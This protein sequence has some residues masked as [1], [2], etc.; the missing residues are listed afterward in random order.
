[1]QYS[2]VNLSKTKDRYD[3]RIDSEFYRTKFLDLEKI[4]NNKPLILLEEAALKVSDGTHF[5][6]T[7]YE[8]GIPFLSAINIQENELDLSRNYQYISPEVHR[9]LYKRCDP[10]ANDILLR[11]VGVGPRWACV[12]PEN[13][14]E[15]SIFVSVAQIRCK[16]SKINRYF[17]ST[18]IN[19]CYGQ[20]QLLRFNK[21]ISQP[22]LHLEDI[23]RLLIPNLNENF[24]KEIERLYLLRQSN[25]NN[26]KKLF[27]EAEQILLSELGLTNWKPGHQ[28]SFVKNY[29]DSKNADRID[30]E[31]FQPIYDEI[32]NAIKSYRDGWDILGNHFIQ[33]KRGFKI[34]PDDIYSYVEISCVRTSD[35]DIEPLVLY[36]NELPP[37]AKI[38]LLRDDILVSKVRPYRGA[39]G[40]IDSD[41]YVGSSA[42]TVLQPSG[43]ITKEALIALL[44]TKPYLLLSLKF[45]T[46]TSYPTIT[47]NDVLNFPIPLLSSDIQREIEKVISE[48]YKA[49]SASK[50]ILDIAKHGVEIA[51]EKGEGEAQDWVS[52]EVKNNA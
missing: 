17:L 7:Y 35:G 19:C 49:K 18:F 26:S 1:M 16:P 30:A 23:R 44:R 31:Y 8:E 46:G 48:A 22:D 50:K 2:T 34:I 40:I 37:N 13:I 25:I 14:N 47:D 52:Q 38:K 10:K 27:N 29:S 43:S 33:N 41:N 4:L 9:G 28:L 39:I 15:F 51:I 6:P 5:T 36:G 12:V 21:G 24:Q 42:F 45:N 11:K 3:F 20:E 32:A